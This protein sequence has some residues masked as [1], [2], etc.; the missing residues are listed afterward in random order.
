MGL[1]SPDFIFI[2][3][4]QGWRY[5]YLDPLGFSNLLLKARFQGY[6]HD[7]WWRTYISAWGGKDHVNSSQ[8]WP[9]N[10]FSLISST[11]LTSLPRWLVYELLQLSY[12]DQLL[13]MVMQGSAV[14]SGVSSIL[15]VLSIK[16]LIALGWLPSHLIRP[17]EIILILYLL[18]DLI[19]RPF[20]IRLI[21]YLLKDSIHQLLEHWVD[22]LGIS[23]IG[24]VSLWMALFCQK[25]FDGLEEGSI[26]SY[27]IY[28][29]SPSIIDGEGRL[30][31]VMWK[32]S[33]INS[34]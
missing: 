27:V 2:R 32:L 8:G 4:A 19:H 1:E 11:S 34:A 10:S 29:N 20:E 9:R 26:S 30:S 6:R 3:E 21:L 15:I 17:F 7:A 22:Y 24:G 16:V 23:F 25:W 31:E 12:F 14:L 28:R 33:P 18:K 5:C 13:K